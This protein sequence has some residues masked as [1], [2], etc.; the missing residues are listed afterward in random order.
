MF[1]YICL[2]NFQTR[3]KSCL[4][5][6]CHIHLLL[7]Y[8]RSPVTR[9]TL[10][11]WSRTALRWQGLCRVSWNSWCLP[12]GQNPDL[13]YG[14]LRLQC[15]FQS[16][17]LTDWNLWLQE[18]LSCPL[19]P[20]GLMKWTLTGLEW[21]IWCRRPPEDFCIP[22]P[23]R[24]VWCIFCSPS[25]NRNACKAWCP[26]PDRWRFLFRSRDLPVCPKHVTAHN[27]LCRFS[28]LRKFQKLS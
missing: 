27:G 28:D 8:P 20:I 18:P 15:S 23:Y 10:P 1:K 24:P 2:R 3:L 12:N 7:F 25:S 19:S 17:L 16:F 11:D 13:L 26:L 22:Q 21:P 14:R 4:M 9:M 6:P 5:T